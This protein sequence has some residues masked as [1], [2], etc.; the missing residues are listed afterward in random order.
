MDATPP[1]TV[2]ARPT[3]HFPQGD[4]VGTTDVS[5]IEEGEAEERM[6]RGQ[7]DGVLRQAELSKLVLPVVRGAGAE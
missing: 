3:T 6:G 2:T 7:G 5:V 4:R 1:A